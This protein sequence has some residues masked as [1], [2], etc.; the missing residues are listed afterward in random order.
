MVFGDLMIMAVFALFFGIFALFLIG[1]GIAAGI[2]L[3]AL[4]GAFTFFGIISTSTLFGILNRSPTAGFRVLFLQ[5]GAAAG[6]PLGIGAAFLWTY[7]FD[8]NL[9]PMDEVLLGALVGIGGGLVAALAFNYG[10]MRALRVILPL[11]APKGPN[12]Y[13]GRS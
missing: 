7:L 2:A 11:L 3:L 9:R 10:W 1:V 13:N 8:E 12:H 5:L 4:A 6:I